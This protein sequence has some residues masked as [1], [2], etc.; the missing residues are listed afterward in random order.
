MADNS[1]TQAHDY[2]HECSICPLESKHN[3]HMKP[4]IRRLATF[5]LPALLLFAATA[6]TNNDP[7]DA[8]TVSGRVM[9]SGQPVNNVLISIDGLMETQT[10]ADG[11]FRLLNV[12]RGNH[13]LNMTK[14]VESGGYVERMLLITVDG[15][16]DLSDQALPAPILLE[17][18]VDVT[19]QTML[20][21]WNSS[22]EPD[23]R[24]YKLYRHNSS[25]LDESTGTLVHV[26]TVRQ[27]TS[28]MV[29]NL[30]PLSDYFFRVYVMN[31]IGRLGGS[32]IVSARTQNKE[33]IK[34]G[35]FEDLRQS[36]GFPE[37]W[38]TWGNSTGYFKV[39][40]DIV[41]T[42]N[43][44]VRV[45]NSGGGVSGMLHQLIRPTDLA[46]GSRYR[47]SYWI[48]HDALIGSSDEFAVFM[49]DEEH[50]WNLYINTTRGPLPESDWKLYEY[51]FTAANLNTA[52]I[53]MAFYFY[54]NS[55]V[56]GDSNIRAWIDDVSLIKID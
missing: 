31:D 28:F 55:S 26:S 44:S 56:H 12:P 4:L 2:S 46:A 53:V 41:R 21:V 52:N 45:E 30:D 13:A 50:T 10:M 33:I 15:N 43:Y 20:L 35:S 8:N 24:E 54:F 27:D 29:S 40:N 48:K 16:T 34:N 42:G 47:L 14:G 5:L 49:N 19:E 7:G 17:E 25:G 32:N 6:C 3:K 36:N 22:G 38:Q 51:E 39:D 37:F 11:T 18:P 9:M 23:F 1:D